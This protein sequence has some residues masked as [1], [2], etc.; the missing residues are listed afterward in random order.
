MAK[1]SFNLE[2]NNKNLSGVNVLFAPTVKED[3]QHKENEQPLET[4]YNE[5]EE[6]TTYPLRLTK[7]LLRQL[8]IMSANTRISIKD[9]VLTAVAEKYKF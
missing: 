9:L 8:K 1:K 7:S 2:D 6:I 5:D 3:K 4:E